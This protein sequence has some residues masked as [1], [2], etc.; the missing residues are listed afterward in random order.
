[1]IVGT[2]SRRNRPEQLGETG[3]L[4]VLARLLP[5]GGRFGQE[6]A[7]QNQRSAGIIP[8]TSV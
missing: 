5:P 7:D 3:R 2:P 4:S 6:W 1:M 8:E